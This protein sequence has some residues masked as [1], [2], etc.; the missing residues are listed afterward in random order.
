MSN[1]EAFGICMA[2]G[3]ILSAAILF[4]FVGLGLIKM[5]KTAKEWGD[6]LT[7]FLYR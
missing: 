4:V 3:V 2:F 1:L 6:A 5:P 7:E